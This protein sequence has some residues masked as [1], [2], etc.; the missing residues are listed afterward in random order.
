MG[1]VKIA[2]TSALTQGKMAGAELGGKHILVVN[3]EGKYY[4]IGNKCTHIGCS[5][6]DGELK[7]GGVVRCPCHGSNFDVKTGKVLKGPAKS[8]EPTF[9]VKVEKDQVLIN[10]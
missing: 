4:A 9:E 1:F 3:V 8:P 5:L 2:S 10:V 6:S 7:E